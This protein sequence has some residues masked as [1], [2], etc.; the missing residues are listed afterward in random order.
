MPNQQQPTSGA[1]YTDLLNQYRDCIIRFCERRFTLFFDHVTPVLHGFAARAEIEVD[2]KRFFEAHEQFTLSRELFWT[3]LREEL[4][5]SFDHPQCCTA[6]AFD[7]T[8]RI[9]DLST[10]AQEILAGENSIIN[11]NAQCFPELYAL[12]QRLGIICNKRKLKDYEILGGPHHLVRSFS[13]ALQSVSLE[14]KPKIILYALFHRVVMQFT[15]LLYQ[16]LN[17]LLCQAGVLP[18]VRPITMRSNQR[19]AARTNQ[20]LK[21]DRGS[22]DT[23]PSLTEGELFNVVLELVSNRRSIA[24]YS[25]IE[26]VKSEITAPEEPSAAPK[27]TDIDVTIDHIGDWFEQ[28]LHMPALPN[29]VKAL[30]SNLHT[31]YLK[32]ALQ[33]ASLF[34]EPDHSARLLLEDLIDAGSLWVDES[35][36]RRGIFPALQHTVEIFLY[37]SRNGR[38]DYERLRTALAQHVVRQKTNCENRE[39]RSRDTLSSRARFQRAKQY[40]ASEIQALTKHYPLPEPVR[41]FLDGTWLDLLTYTLLRK[42][43]GPNS[44]AWQETIQ[45]ARQLVELFDPRVDNDEL[46]NRLHDLPQ[47]RK[48]IVKGIRRLGSHNQAVLATVNAI[49]SNPRALRDHVRKQSINTGNQT[50][51]R[52]AAEVRN[53]QQHADVAD[54][55]SQSST[56]Q[57]DHDD[58]VRSLSPSDLSLQAMIEQLRQTKSG[59]W[60]E[61]TAHSHHKRPRRIKLSWISPLT[62]SCMFVDQSGLQ[63]DIY[64]LEDLAA[65]LLSGTARVINH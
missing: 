41:A 30:L 11:T 18:K 54:D 39:R 57:Q 42:H 6:S 21:T 8:G 15:P 45:T 61:L 60:F 49:L 62:S 44:V 3:Q 52:S 55:G 29:I 16:E 63:A 20:T 56:V 28:M 65:A 22:I 43:D 40:A 48:L 51:P 7:Q 37:E 1:H 9:A 33:D 50:M 2:R 53:L 17:D 14:S 34:T 47:L 10:D 4:I 27:Q 32:L 46:Q 64:H 36:P 12:S 25:T 31:S 23:V 58:Q 26:Y 19:K 38:V 35:N 59:T 24:P 5:F 13:K